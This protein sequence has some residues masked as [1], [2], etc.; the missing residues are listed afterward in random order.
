MGGLW[1]D[2]HQL[3]AD[4]IIDHCY[5]WM[6]RIGWITNFDRAAGEADG[7]HDGIEFVDSE[8][9]KLLEAMAWELGIRP[10]EPCWRRAITI[11]CD[12]WVPHRRPTAIFTRASGAMA[13]ARGTATLS[14][15]T[16]ST[17]SATSFRQR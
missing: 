13:S 10:D 6:S 1:G 17:V 14:G 7:E 3:N 2:L 9:Y 11:W 15:A 4:V 12:G 8:V 16:S 5:S